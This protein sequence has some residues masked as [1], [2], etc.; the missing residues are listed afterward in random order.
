MITTLHASAHRAEAILNSLESGEALPALGTAISQVIAIASSSDDSVSELTRFILADA[1]LTQKILGIANTVEYRS[2]AGSQVT[3]ISR[4][5]MLLG[6]DLVKTSAM[7]ILMAE[8]LRSVSASEAV[9]GQLL[10]A[11][12]ASLVVRNMTARFSPQQLEEAA[13]AALFRN[14]GSLLIAVFEPALHTLLQSRPG[15]PAV[16]Q[17]AEDLLGVSVERLTVSVLQH[18]KIPELI[19][20]ATQPCTSGVQAKAASRSEWLRQ[21]V[22]FATELVPAIMVQGT[23]SQKVQSDCC[24]RFS[25][26]LDINDAALHKLVQNVQHEIH[27]LMTGLGWQSNTTHP[28]DT[29]HTHL[30]DDFL[31]QPART[32]GSVQHYPS[33][34]PF[35]ARQLL[36]AGL[37][38]LRNSASSAVSPL[39]DRI[40]PMLEVLYS[41]LGFRTISLLLYDHSNQR[42]ISV[43][44]IGSAMP[45]WRQPISGSNDIFVLALQK[46]LDIVVADTLD[47]RISDR[48]PEWLGQ[49]Y[50]DTRSMLL[51]PL[52]RAEKRFGLI[53]AERERS[54]GEGYT[55]DESELM[56]MLRQR[57]LQLLVP[58]TDT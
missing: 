7:A 22:T 54:A 36:L 20:Q 37:Q 45:E 49:R 29:G 30:G 2:R 41:A 26:A 8:K 12:C 15:D 3:T 55:A 11:L 24:K 39:N 5:V 38:E 46:N 58:G 47:S 23:A 34:K 51:M 31:L 6:F 50:P 44:S 40:I 18:W 19:I 33:G 4:S 27:A 57:M 1:G 13:V 53:F 9:R 42:W 10:Q 32:A 35:A 56:N 52:V 48:L 28:A 25:A 21:M 43:M 17:Q 14:T 16:R